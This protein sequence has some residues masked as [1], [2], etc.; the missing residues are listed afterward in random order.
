VSDLFQAAGLTEEAPRPLADRLRPESIEDVVGQDHLL[1]PEGPIGRMLAQGRL[2]AADGDATAR[3]VIAALDLLA[4]R[5]GVSQAAVAIAW[6]LAHPARPVALI[7]SQTPQR[8]K[9]AA[10]ALRVQLS[11]TDWY[12]VL[13]AARG[14]PMP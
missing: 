8:L 1:G 14:A 9:D 6:V 3:R 7:G 10:A 2:A 5:E 12:G 13:V 11:R 4:V